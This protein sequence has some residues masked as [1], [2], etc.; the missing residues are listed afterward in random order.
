VEESINSPI[1][2]NPWAYFQIR[3]GI[4]VARPKQSRIGID[5]GFGAPLP[6]LLNPYFTITN[7][8]TGWN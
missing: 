5:W 4:P 2:E 1:K 8:W 3:T 6:H 7:Q